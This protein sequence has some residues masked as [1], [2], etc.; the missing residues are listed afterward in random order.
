MN[1]NQLSG[2]A[3][4]TTRENCSLK[5]NKIS[6]KQLSYWK[7]MKGKIPWNKGLTKSDPRVAKSIKNWV[8][9]LK[10]R[11]LT[12]IERKKI[13]EGAKAHNVGK[14]M[15]GRKLSEEIRKKISESI[16]GPKN[17]Q[18]ISDR[19]LLPYSDEFNDE[20]KEF[21][22]NRDGR[23]CKLCGKTEEQELKQYARRLCVN[24]IDY[25]KKNCS[26]ENLNTLCMMCNKQVNHNREYWT[27]YFQKQ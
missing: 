27:N 11:K 3:L 16:R 18:W 23:I 20:L 4:E 1:I 19:S 26:P 7:S 8:A 14:W 2:N 10:G 25:N 24:H 12:E 6:E 15:E 21:I 9:P 13:S 22:R 5:S 17:Y